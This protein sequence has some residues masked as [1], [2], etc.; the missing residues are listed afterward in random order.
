[1]ELI[2]RVLAGVIAAWIPLDGRQE[3]RQR[4]EGVRAESLDGRAVVGTR[5]IASYEG[6]R[7][8]TRQEKRSLTSH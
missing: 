5:K 8:D 3:R 2:T 1:M 4:H 7:R 6:R